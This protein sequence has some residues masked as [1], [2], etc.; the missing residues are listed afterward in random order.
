[1]KTEDEVFQ[2]VKHIVADIIAKKKEIYEKLK[3]EV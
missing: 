1:L 2:G 3:K